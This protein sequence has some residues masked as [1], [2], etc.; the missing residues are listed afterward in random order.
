ML[1]GLKVLPGRKARQGRMVPKACQEHKDP[2]G[3]RVW[4]GLADR[5][6][7]PALRARLG[8]RDHKGPREQRAHKDLRALLARQAL[9]SIRCR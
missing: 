8:Q 7:P 6:A 9:E 1:R 5:L 3:R 4:Q 2:K